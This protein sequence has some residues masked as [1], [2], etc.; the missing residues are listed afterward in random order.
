MVA[1][2]SVPFLAGT[3]PSCMEQVRLAAIEAAYAMSAAMPE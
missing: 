1:A 2:I 3:Q